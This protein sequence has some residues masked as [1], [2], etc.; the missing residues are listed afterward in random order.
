[1]NNQL[2]FRET[3]GLAYF[4]LIWS[5]LMLAGAWA[6][7]ETKGWL[8]SWKPQLQPSIFCAPQIGNAFIGGPYHNPIASMPICQTPPKT[9]WKGPGQPPPTTTIVI[10]KV[11]LQGPKNCSGIKNRRRPRV[12]HEDGCIPL[13]PPGFQAPLV[14]STNTSAGGSTN[15]S[16]G[17][18]GNSNQGSGTIQPNP[19]IPPAG[20]GQNT[21][22]GNTSGQTSKIQ[23]NQ[24]ASP[25]RPTSNNWVG[26]KNSSGTP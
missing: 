8:N 3:Q 18:G 12:W 11:R 17:G 22:G 25:N 19:W 16:G 6:V 5:L 26:P 15:S 21:G 1:M 14:G 20:T 23:T 4:V 7:D 9:N 10:Q 13:A 24:G 2:T